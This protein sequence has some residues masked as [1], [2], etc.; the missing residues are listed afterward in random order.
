VD[1]SRPSSAARLEAIG[2]RKKNFRY[3]SLS[4]FLSHYFIFLTLTS[5]FFLPLEPSSKEYPGLATLENPRVL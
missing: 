4:P 2:G 1:R 3:L 5:F